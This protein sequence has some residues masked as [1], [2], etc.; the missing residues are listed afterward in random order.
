VALFYVVVVRKIRDGWE[1][2]KQIEGQMAHVF[3]N[4][5]HSRKVDHR[6]AVMI[7]VLEG[8]L[9]KISREHPANTPKPI[10]KL[11]RPNSSGEFRAVEIAPSTMCCAS[12]KRLTGRSYLLLEAPRLPLHGCTMPT[13]CSCKFLKNADRRDSDRRLFGAT[14]TNRWFAGVESRKRRGRRSEEE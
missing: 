14:E 6:S 7:K 11:K 4:H 1:E 12:A 8:L 9:A 3:T 2:K 10:A 13:V 5:M